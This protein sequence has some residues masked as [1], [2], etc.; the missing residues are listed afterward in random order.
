MEIV[1]VWM[2]V[3]GYAAAYTGMQT[4]AGYTIG[5]LSSLGL[6]PLPDLTASAGPIGDLVNPILGAVSSIAGSSTTLTPFTPQYTG[7]YPPGYPL[8]GQ[9]SSLKKGSIT[10]GIEDI[11]KT[12]GQSVPTSTAPTTAGSPSVWSL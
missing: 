6:A 12:S 10:G 11:T 7:S 2:V 1:G 3:F 4:F 5:V 8:P 9:T